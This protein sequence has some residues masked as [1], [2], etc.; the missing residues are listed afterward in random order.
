MRVIA[1]DLLFTWK[2]DQTQSEFF[3]FFWVRTGTQKGQCHELIEM[4]RKHSCNKF[5]S[6]RKYQIPSQFWTSII[7]QVEKQEN[8]S[9][10]SNKSGHRQSRTL[11]EMGPVEN[12]VANFAYHF[13]N[14]T[15]RKPSR[16][17]KQKLRL[18]DTCAPLLQKINGAINM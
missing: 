5:W 16:K 18:L 7:T 4:I 13:G 2:G 9:D 1:T 11:I 12:Q 14:T 6:A 8:G 15:G 3:F 10:E 17:N